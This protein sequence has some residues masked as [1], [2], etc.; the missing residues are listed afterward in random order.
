MEYVSFMEN[1]G[2]LKAVKVRIYPT[3][4]QSQFLN[5]QFG[6]VRFVYNK[7]LAIINHFYKIRHKSL[8][9]TRD[10]KP[11]LA[12]AKRSRKYHWLKNYDSIAL[13]EGCRNLD[14]AFQKFFKKEA[15]Y[16]NYKKKH[17]RQSS[18]HCTGLSWGENWIKI[19][20]LKSSIK[21]KIH[22]K[23]TGLIKSITLEKASTGKYHAA[24]LVEDG[25][26]KPIPLKLLA[27]SRV[28][29]CDMGLHHLLISSNGNKISNPKFLDKSR[30]N[31]RRKQQN[32]S[33][34]IKGSAKRA[35][36]RLLVA[37]CHER[38]KNSRFDFQH[39]LSK[40]LI[41]ENQAIGVETL[42]V[43]NMLK[44]R[45]LSRA[46]ADA[47]W[48]KLIEKLTYKAEDSGKHLVKID[49]WYASSKT[50]HNCDYKREKLCLSEREWDCP[51]CYH[52]HDRDINASLNIEKQ[53]ILQLKAAGLSVSA[54]G[55]L[56]KTCLQ[57]VA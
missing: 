13:Q 21:A 41:D 24:I 12:T 16:P 37:K 38:T 51:K 45:R 35:K 47:A 39:K 56:R 23:L 55:G 42:K 36:A 53:T 28:L 5:Q 20:K 1:M 22:R 19:P 11:L 34:K 29:G 54:R 7:S 30:R 8:K 3:R 25:K 32:L 33:R 44:N 43:K 48:G 18:Y 31:L 40:R 15:G 50:C 14:K 57:A 46:I 4:N 27:S 52:H 17:L 49:Q 2:M 10:I 26:K 6:A 9:P